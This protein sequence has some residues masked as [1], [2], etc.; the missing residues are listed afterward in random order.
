MRFDKKHLKNLRKAAPSEC[1][2]ADPP[3]ENP[4]KR[5]AR[6]AYFLRKALARREAQRRNPAGVRA[7]E[8]VR[9]ALA[10]GEL[11]R[12]RCQLGD[13]GCLEWPV[14]AHHTSYAPEDWLKVVW[15]CK[16][17]HGRLTAHGAV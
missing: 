13:P 3:P 1:Y 11:V 9:Q 4:F 7:R 6:E 14:E 15:V 12:E 16:A 10:R 17:C 5:A 2:Q 8:A